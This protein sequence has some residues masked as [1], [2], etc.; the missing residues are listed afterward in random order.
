[1]DRLLFIQFALGAITVSNN[2]RQL[3]KA[4]HLMLLGGGNQI[5]GGQYIDAP[6]VSVGNRIGDQCGGVNNDIAA[7]K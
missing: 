6:H 1:M 4:A 5:A 2:G 3:Y 7:L